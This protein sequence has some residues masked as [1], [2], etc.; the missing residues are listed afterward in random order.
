M[1]LKPFL[2]VFAAALVAA[3]PAQSSDDDSLIGEMQVFKRG[4][5]LT[6]RDVEL[7]EMHRVNLTESKLQTQNTSKQMML[8]RYK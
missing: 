5:G 3:A 8:T 4:S 2:P 6:T 1:L 7:A